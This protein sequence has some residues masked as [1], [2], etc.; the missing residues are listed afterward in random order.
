MRAARIALPLLAALLCAASA[1]AMP[2]SAA[3]HIDPKA[4]CYRWPAVDW[5]GDG[6]FDRI[7]RCPDTPKGC[8]VDQ[9]GCS[10]DSDGDGV[11]DGIDRCPD[12]PRGQKVDA[13]G[14]SASQRTT[15]HVA[16]PPAEPPREVPKPAPVPQPAPK[17]VSESERQLIESG[18]IRLENVYFET[19]KAKLLP[20]S[21]ASLREAGEA[22]EKFPNLQ[23][24]VEGH[25]DTRGTAPYNKR[26]SQARAETVR[27]WLL[28]H[29]HLRSENFVAHGY[30]KERPET[31]ERND[32]E[33]LRNRR[34]VLTVKNPEDLPK[35]VRVEN[36]K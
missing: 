25:T 19:A 29:Y 34:V 1:H 24:E 16:P 22:L 20:E 21:E 30:G 5:D 23:I 14:C 27:S 13:Y 35:G 18:R 15:A 4:P 31:K 8:K 9:W 36:K 17:S 10:L 2:P 7:D 6:V 11:C 26:L 32:E 28:E 3:A 33:L 12:T